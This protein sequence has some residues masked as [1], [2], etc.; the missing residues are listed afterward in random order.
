MP[1]F[2]FVGSYTSEGSKGMLKE[3][4]VKRKAAIEEAIKSVGGTLEACYFALG[5]YDFVLLTD[6]PDN[7]SA[8]GLLSSCVGTIRAEEEKP[9]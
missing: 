7:V 4:G 6:M 8:A 9:G 1:K 5:E 2:L 3:G